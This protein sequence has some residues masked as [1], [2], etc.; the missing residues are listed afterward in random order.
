MNSEKSLL[1]EIHLV[2]KAM[3]I[4]EGVEF[5]QSL[6]GDWVIAPANIKKKYSSD[7]Q[8]QHLSMLRLS[9]LLAYLI[10]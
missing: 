5:I 8:Q 1:T 7:L 2:G 3:K 6:R 4:N 10:L 9:E